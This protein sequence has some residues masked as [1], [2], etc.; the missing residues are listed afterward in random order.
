MAAA[1]TFAPVQD[2]MFQHTFED[3]FEGALGTNGMAALFASDNFH[4]CLLVCPTAT[5]DGASGATWRLD[6]ATG[7]RQVVGELA[8]PTCA[9]VL[10]A[11]QGIVTG[12]RWYTVS[13]TE[14]AQQV[15]VAAAYGAVGS[16]VAGV[17]FKVDVDAFT[18][19]SL[20]VDDD[21]GGTPGFVVGMCLADASGGTPGTYAG[22][23]E[24][25]FWI[26]E[27]G[28]NFMGAGSNVTYTPNA[29]S[30]LFQFVNATT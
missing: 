11:A 12:A 23:D 27:G 26:D 5:Y 10:A 21:E 1:S 25:R 17:G 28:F 6:D 16:D 29:S 8:A 20:A 24:C 13:A 4:A 2:F 22:T 9:N 30:G 18:F 3:M 14:I 15:T 7:F 19:A